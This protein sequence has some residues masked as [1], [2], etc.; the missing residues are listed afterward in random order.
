LVADNEV[1]EQMVVVDVG[2][3]AMVTEL[4]AAHGIDVAEVE[5]RTFDP[6]TA[7]ALL[8]I[9]SPMAVGTV[10]YLLDRAKGGQVIDLREDAP[11]MIYRTTDLVY[12]LIVIVAKDGA[13]S[14]EVKEPKG[15]LGSVLDSLRGVLSD[16]A[17][18]SVDTATAS[19]KAAVGDRAI[20]RKLDP[21]EASSIV[22]RCD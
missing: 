10:T 17:A 13:V 19:V 6:V 3:R 20:V 12:G 18:K 16:V 2:D 9:G 8:L 21:S 7:V 11:K 1:V 4:A 14:V 5:R 22:N 15:M